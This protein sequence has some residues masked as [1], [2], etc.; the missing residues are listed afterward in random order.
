MD[1]GV[2]VAKPMETLIIQDLIYGS[3]ILELLAFAKL[4]R[5]N[6][7]Y[8]NIIA[9]VVKLEDSWLL[10]MPILCLTTGLNNRRDVCLVRDLH[11]SRNIFRSQSQR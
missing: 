1:I 7:I 6:I 4:S 3:I 9:T 11:I 5:A 10:L 2:I 8:S